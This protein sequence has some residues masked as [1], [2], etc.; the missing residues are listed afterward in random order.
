MGL[1]TQKDLVIDRGGILGAGN[2]L[3]PPSGHARESEQMQ[4]TEMSELLSKRGCI[5]TAA[6][7]KEYT[8]PCR[9]KVRTQSGPVLADQ[10]AVIDEK[11]SKAD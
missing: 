9:Y 4:L 11:R 6:M 3:E 8:Y 10:P 1:T 5:F 2:P 7:Q